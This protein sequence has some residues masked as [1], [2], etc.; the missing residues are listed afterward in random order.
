VTDFARLLAALIDGGVEFV[1]HH[2]VSLSNSM[3]TPSGVA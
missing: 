3:S 2:L 1:V